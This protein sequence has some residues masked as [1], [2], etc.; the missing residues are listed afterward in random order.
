ML[1]AD[2]EQKIQP[3][4]S[5]VA[6]YLDPE[7]MQAVSTLRGGKLADPQT[8]HLGEAF[9][10]MLLESFQGAFTEFVFME[11]PPTEGLMRQYGIPY[12]VEV[13]IRDF[14]NRVTLKGQSVALVAEAIVRDQALNQIARFESRGESRAE[15]VFAKKGGP[16]V[17]L[18]AA[19]EN[20]VLAIVQYLQGSIQ[21]GNWGEASDV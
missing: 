4:E 7:I 15:K 17:N 14:Y 5:R 20:N 8:Y 19:I 2:F 12:V 9:V 21:T 10:P 1:S 3:I 13:R 18:N 6:L 16:E 11:I